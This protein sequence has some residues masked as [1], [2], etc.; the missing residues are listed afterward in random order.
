MMQTRE[1]KDVLGTSAADQLNLFFIA[2][3]TWKLSQLDIKY[4][5]I[6]DAALGKVI[7]S[8][9]LTFES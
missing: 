5:Q 9:L 3:P 7:T 2:N 4:F 6:F 8:I 1:F